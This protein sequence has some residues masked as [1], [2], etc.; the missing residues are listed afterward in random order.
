MRCGTKKSLSVWHPCATGGCKEAENLSVP[1]SLRTGTGALR[2]SP[3]SADARRTR[4]PHAQ[5][6]FLLVVWREKPV[7]KMLCMV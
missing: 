3:L 7:K 1:K 2:F 5:G 6:F 4:M